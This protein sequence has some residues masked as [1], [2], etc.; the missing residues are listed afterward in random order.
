MNHSIYF[1][2]LLCYLVIRN[3]IVHILSAENVVLCFLAVYIDLVVL[4]ILVDRSESNVLF[5]SVISKFGL[6]V[7]IRLAYFPEL[8]IRDIWCLR[9]IYFHLLSPRLVVLRQLL[10]VPGD[11]LLLGFSFLVQYSRTFIVW[12]LR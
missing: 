9:L 10:L 3:T 5:R 8:F 6:V 12:L 2:V 1:G 7:G 11:P 4:H